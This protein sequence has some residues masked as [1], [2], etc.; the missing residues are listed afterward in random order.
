MKSGFR[1]NR[2]LKFCLSLILIFCPAELRADSVIILGRF[3]QAPAPDA[4][5][6]GWQVIRIKGN[7]N[8]TLER[9]QGETHLHMS[10][11]GR[12]SFGLKRALNINTDR[13]PYLN[14]EW[15]A[16]ALP[17]GGDVRYG[18]RDDQAAQ[19]YVAFSASGKFSLSNCL[20]IGYIWDN[21][22]P[23]GWSGPGPQPGGNRI[24]Y[25]VLRNK[26]DMTPFWVREK[27]NVMQDFETL[28]KEPAGN[29]N[30]TGVSVFIN[31][32]HTGTYAES[33]FRDIFFSRN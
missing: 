22:A 28:F 20:L 23:K 24:R 6:P 27:R 16:A 11:D 2:I 1:N 8:F 5:P 21:E 30:V 26:T 15:H 29:R 14:W 13:Y 7:P 4:P 31:A 9:E 10:S 3:E 17:A 32:H 25:L 12:S 18:S 19:V 33:Y